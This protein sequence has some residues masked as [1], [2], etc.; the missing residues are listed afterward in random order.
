[1]FERTGLVEEFGRDRFFPNKENA[2]RSLLERYDPAV[3]S[4]VANPV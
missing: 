3:T 1:V 4:R 2:L